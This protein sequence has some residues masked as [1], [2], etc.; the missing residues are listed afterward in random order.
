MELRELLRD[1]FAATILPAIYAD[2]QTFCREYGGNRGENW[3]EE[4]VLEA[5]KMADAM[6]AIRSAKVSTGQPDSAS[7]MSR[8][9]PSA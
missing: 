7:A 1:Q 2:Y 4:I 9:S 8:R 3:R 5:Y 6:I